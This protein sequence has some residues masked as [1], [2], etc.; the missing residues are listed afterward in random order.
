MC[1][2]QSFL[3]S[4]SE[5]T[6]LPESEEFIISGNSPA[7]IFSDVLCSSSGTRIHLSF[8]TF[9]RIFISVL[10]SLLCCA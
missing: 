5:L 7:I 8:L 1:L 9:S 2:G 4:H 10:A 3:K 6:V